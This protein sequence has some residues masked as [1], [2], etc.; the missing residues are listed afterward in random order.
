[1]LDMILEKYIVELRGGKT[2]YFL[3]E[4]KTEL[5]KPSY[6]PFPKDMLPVQCTFHDENLEKLSGYTSGE[7]SIVVPQTEYWFKAKGI[8]I[9]SGVSKPIF[10]EGKLFSY[11]LSN[12]RVG[13]G[14]IIWGFSSYEEAK[15]ELY[16]MQRANE[17]GVPASIPI[18]LGIYEKIVV[19]D[20]KNRSGLFQYLNNVKTDVLRDFSEKGREI[21]GACVFCRCTSDIRVDEVLYPFMFPTV[22][23]ILDLRD[24]KD[25][26]MWLGSSCGYN[27]RLH[28]DEGMTHGTMEKRFGFITN[29][30]LANHT[31]EESETG[32][33]DYHLSG[34]VNNKLKKLELIFLSYVMNPLPYARSLGMKKFQDWGMSAF[35]AMEELP[36][37]SYYDHFNGY[38][39]YEKKAVDFT[40]AFMK[41]LEKGYYRRRI[42]D[43]D[44]KLKRKMLYRLVN[45]RH[46]LWQIYDV[47]QGLQ[48]GLRYIKARISLKNI[49]NSDI[50]NKLISDDV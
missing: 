34:E 21:S 9:P 3:I 7:R 49:N 30:H 5:S 16:W 43:I 28:H 32:T 17:V 36:S 10:Q 42:L 11:F 14:E 44:K 20:F 37:I 29:S 26:L 48:R 8:G 31:I 27:L 6:Y 40:M 50:E 23:K 15:E 39:N 45:L 25:Y 2:P 13:S 41:G 4:G 19:L 12:A 46:K 18:G 38:F 1:M 33:T 47:P 22:E 35:S 24:C